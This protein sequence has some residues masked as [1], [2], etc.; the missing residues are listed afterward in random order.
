M[1]WASDVDEYVSG[2]SQDCAVAVIRPSD[3]RVQQRWTEILRWYGLRIEEAALPAPRLPSA[4]HHLVIG[5][6]DEFSEVAA[7][8]A[9]S[10]Q[11]EFHL[12]K[13]VGDLQSL[14]NEG[15]Y[16]SNLIIGTPR[17]LSF[18]GTLGPHRDQAPWGLITAHDA[19]GLTFAL[20]KATALASFPVTR[21]HSIDALGSEAKL[22]VH[23][24]DEIGQELPSSVS[25][26]DLLSG[27]AAE[28]LIICAHGDA[29]HFNLKTDVLCAARHVPE[30]DAQGQLVEGCLVI[31]DVHRCRRMQE[32]HL[33]VQA[34]GSIQTRY[35]ALLSCSSAGLP[36]VQGATD[37]SGVLSVA[38]GYPA[39]LIA[40]TGVMEIRSES[41]QLLAGCTIDAAGMELAAAQ[42]NGLAPI[43]PLRF[44]YVFFGDPSVSS[45][46][47][48]GEDAVSQS[49]ENGRMMWL[50]PQRTGEELI[51]IVPE[52]DDTLA[53][54]GRKVAAILRR[55][56][57]ARVRPVEV[58]VSSAHRTHRLWF[59]RLAESVDTARRMEA[60]IR[61]SLS[62]GKERRVPLDALNNVLHTRQHLED[63]TD[64]ALDA[65][66]RAQDCGVW[67]E[68]LGSWRSLAMLAVL[69]HD[70]AVADL[71]HSQPQIWRLHEILAR[72]FDR[73][74]VDGD[75]LCPI[76]HCGIRKET[77]VDPIGRH[78]GF[79]FKHCQWHGLLGWK[80]VG[81]PELRLEQLEGLTPGRNCRIGVRIHR[82]GPSPSSEADRGWVVTQFR[83]RIT[84]ELTPGVK[85][86]FADEALELEVPVPANLSCTQVHTIEGAYISA[87]DLTL[88]NLDVTYWSPMAGR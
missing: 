74:D 88:Q 39:A 37:L 17:R 16:A 78:P 48:G 58:E 65:L 68:D 29:G 33:R 47:C 8:F 69:A 15:R 35:L 18:L 11:R 62:H 70:R 30:R 5:I 86:E 84:T 80:R 27:H 46:R 79:V 26:P 36:F 23:S 71:L 81:G 72:S 43:S 53:F 25:V 1:F 50:T 7:A 87:L 57:G 67:H 24:V 12:L 60:A 19:P 59:V 82:E 44:P 32:S 41:A 10:R 73:G 2:W 13:K 64:S 49:T 45:I 6:D 61:R 38:E 51:R 14:L 3:P 9:R 63:L 22:A 56:A 83:N 31:D 34:H 76:C 21:C 20:A 40:L 77:F 85:L 66:R 55:S 4:E 42:L 28:A 75:G 54:A 52:T